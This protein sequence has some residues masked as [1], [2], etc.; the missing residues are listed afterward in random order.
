VAA[1][2]TTFEISLVLQLV[3]LPVGSVEIKGVADEI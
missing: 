1:D 3:V 2:V